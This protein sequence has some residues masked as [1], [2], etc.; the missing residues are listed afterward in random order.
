MSFQRITTIGSIPLTNS[1]ATPSRCSRSPSSSRRLTSASAAPCRRRAQARE[2]GDD[3]VGG[4]DEHGGHLGPR[5][6]RRLD[7]VEDHPVGGLLGEVDDV[8]ERGREL[9]AVGGVDRQR[10]P[11]RS[12]GGG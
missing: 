6:H 5:L 2:G 11:R 1:D 10:A 9:V 8:V 4:G 3:L 12:A 7:R